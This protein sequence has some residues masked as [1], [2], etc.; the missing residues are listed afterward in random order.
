MEKQRSRNALLIWVLLV[1]LGSHNMVM[2]VT[3]RNLEEGLSDQ[4]NYYSHDPHNGGAPKSH[5]KGKISPI[6][7]S[8]T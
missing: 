7:A 8:A 5:H 4:K 1:G 3:S 2:L 6:E